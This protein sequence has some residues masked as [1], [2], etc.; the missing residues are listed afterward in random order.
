[1]LFRP[2]RTIVIV[3]IAFVAGMVYERSNANERCLN[4]GGTQI[5]GICEK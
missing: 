1:M 3:T 4:A 2:I 5:N